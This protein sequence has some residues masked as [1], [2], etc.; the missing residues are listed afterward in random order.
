MPRLSRKD[1]ERISE[2]VYAA[3]R[4][5]PELS[6]EKIYSVDP[7]LMLKLLRLK[8]DHCY[9]SKD[10]TIL[11]MTSFSEVSVGVWDNN[12]EELYYFLDGNTVLVDSR[13]QEDASQ[14]GRYHFTIMHEAGHQILGM[15]FPGDYKQHAA[16]VHYCKEYQF[17]RP[18]MDWEEW[19]ANT[20][21]ASLLMP[22]DLVEQGMFLLGLGDALPILNRK[23]RFKDYDR[24]V[25]LSQLLGVSK[26]ALAIRMKHLGLLHD[27][28]LQNPDIMIEVLKDRQ[29]V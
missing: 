18:I 25:C 22:R 27:D 26:K 29:E 15:L 24:F 20:L 8:L 4:K 2:R 21:A 14:Y 3:Y 13:L 12:S 28:Q 1:I 23:Y 5:S 19:Q 7:M 6:G 17:E 11:G 16:R 9:L 10:C